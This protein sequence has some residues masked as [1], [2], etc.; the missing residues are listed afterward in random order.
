MEANSSC[1]RNLQQS[2]QMQHADRCSSAAPQELLSSAVKASVVSLLTDKN[3][4]RRVRKQIRTT[5]CFCPIPRFF[6]RSGFFPSE[7]STTQLRAKGGDNLAMSRSSDHIWGRFYVTKPSK[8]FPPNSGK[9]QCSSGTRQRCVWACPYPS[10][11]R[12][13]VRSQAAG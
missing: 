3:R 10:P 2:K 12:R 4:W 7:F 11:S 5:C 6:S 13:L 1:F 8:T 9:R